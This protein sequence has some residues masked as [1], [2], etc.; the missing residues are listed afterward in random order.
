MG[1]VLCRECYATRTY[2]TIC[3]QNVMLTVVAFNFLFLLI[4][5]G[6]P[7]LCEGYPKHSITKQIA[8][9]TRAHDYVISGTKAHAIC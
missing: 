4:M 8:L 2:K 6:L 3:E 5:L 1:H 9:N 7:A